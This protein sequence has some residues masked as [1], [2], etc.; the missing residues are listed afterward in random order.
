MVLEERDAALAAAS[1]RADEAIARVADLTAAVAA[2][3]GERARLGAALEGASSQ[4]AVYTAMDATLD[5]AVLAAGARIGEA[6]GRGWLGCNAAVVG[7]TCSYSC[8][9]TA[10]PSVRLHACLP[11][12]VGTGTAQGY[13]ETCVMSL[14]A[15]PLLPRLRCVHDLKL[16]SLWLHSQM[17][18]I[19]YF[20]APFISRLL[21]VHLYRILTA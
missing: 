3:E 15:L 8:R 16:A 13:S 7:L 9:R 18:S 17:L 11:A 2:L 10:V 19:C 20:M 21:P 4:L 14:L 5:E 1:R 12:G 6:G